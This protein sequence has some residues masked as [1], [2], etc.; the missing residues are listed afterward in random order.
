MRAA[1][2]V[3][4]TRFLIAALLAVAVLAPRLN[5]QDL[6]IVQPIKIIERR[7]GTD[8]FQILQMRGSR[9][10]NDRTQRVMLA[11]TDSSV[12]EAKFAAF[13]PNGETFN[14]NPRYEIAAYELQKMFL[15]EPDYVVP[16]TLARAFNLD[17]YRTHFDPEVK[18]TFGKTTTVF[19]TLQYWLGNVTNDTA[20]VFDL[21]R[22]ERD[23]AYARHLGNLNLLT[24]LIKHNDANV[25]N[26]LVSTSPVNPRLFSVDNGVA[27]AGEESDRGTVWREIR[28]PRVP[29]A[30]IERLRKLTKEDLE[31][32]LGVLAEWELKGTIFAPVEKTENSSRGRG[33]RKTDT[34]LQMGL[35]RL[36]LDGVDQRLKNLLRRVDSGR[37]KTF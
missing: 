2:L 30:T 7:L 19:S 3:I 5:A 18:P 37:L 20:A 23:T 27:F 26:V 16:P 29:A 10:P 22:F 36:E 11:F 8:T 21:R 9:R 32:T 35:T 25:G 4:R 12:L 31:R 17:W 1:A 14:N 34:R 6:N 33:V 28:V 24:Y 15:D 13:A